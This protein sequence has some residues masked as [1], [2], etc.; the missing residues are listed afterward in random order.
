[1]IHYDRQAY[2]EMKQVVFALFDF[3][4]KHRDSIFAKR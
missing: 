4:K 2:E 1:M 3:L